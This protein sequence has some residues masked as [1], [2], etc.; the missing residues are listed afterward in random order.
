[1]VKFTL[2]SSNS[3]TGPIPVMGSQSSTCPDACPLKKAGCYAK[4]GPISWHWAKLNKGTVGISWEDF[5]IAVKGLMRGQLWRMNE[6]GDIQGDNNQ[7][8]A[9][10]LFQLIAANR[11]RNGF[12]YSH[13]PVLNEQ[14]EFASANREAIANANKNGLTINLSANDLNHADKLK[15]LNIAPVC[16]VLPHDAPKMQITKAGN[17]VVICPAQ[18]IEGMTCSIC[19]LCQKVSRSVIVGFRSHGAGAK[20]VDKLSQ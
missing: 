17:K 8:D 6:H 7:I 18:Q 12:G 4:Y 16:V 14:S 13:K 1:M 3:K 2:V 5:L 19:Q 10:K 9:Q 20:H 11:G 15:E